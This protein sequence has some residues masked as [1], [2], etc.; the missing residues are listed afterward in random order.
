V[1]ASATIQIFIEPTAWGNR[2]TQRF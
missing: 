1:G 2:S